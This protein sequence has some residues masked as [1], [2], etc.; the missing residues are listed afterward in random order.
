MFDKD[1]IRNYLLALN[2]TGE[3]SA[4]HVPSEKYSQL[5]QAYY[6]IYKDLSKQNI[7]IDENSQDSLTTFF[8][9]NICTEFK[10]QPYAPTI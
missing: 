3:G 6:K 8:Q 10:S 5:L 4:P 2:Y 9:K 1:I 7:L